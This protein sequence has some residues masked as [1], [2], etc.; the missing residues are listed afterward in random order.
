MDLT[1]WDI[2][3]S[4]FKEDAPLYEKLKIL[5]RYAILAP[6]GHNTQ[7]WRFAVDD[8]Q[9]KVLA[10][11]S[12]ALPA[13]D[14]DNRELYISVGCAVENL[15]TAGRHFGYIP[16]VKY[17][18]DGFESECVAAIGFSRSEVAG[19]NNLFYSITKKWRSY[20]LLSL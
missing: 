19:K 2:K 3:E 18:P 20:R 1:A 13:A 6:S 11:L 17:F 5:L 10:D 16:D 7:P 14:P 12:R 8:G 9:I 15:I 4:E